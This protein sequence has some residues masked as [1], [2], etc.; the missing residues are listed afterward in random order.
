MFLDR[1]H[2][3]SELTKIVIYRASGIISKRTRSD[4]TTLEK[5]KKKNLSYAIHTKTAPHLKYNVMIT[6]K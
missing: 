1:K 5:K 2:D 4:Y 3:Y 6:L